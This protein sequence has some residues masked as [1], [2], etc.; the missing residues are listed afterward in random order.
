LFKEFYQAQ[1]SILFQYTL[2]LTYIDR[3]QTGHIL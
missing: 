2:N 1:D 3:A